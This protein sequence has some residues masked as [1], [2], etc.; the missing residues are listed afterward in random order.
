MRERARETDRGRD[1][2]RESQRD[3]DRER[4]KEERKH[5]QGATEREQERQ[6]KRL[7]CRNT[8]L[9][10]MF[11]SLAVVRAGEYCTYHLGGSRHDPSNYAIKWCEHDCCGDW[12]DQHC[13]PAV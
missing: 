10:R 9:S 3:R 5:R 11:S 13:C 4:D 12:P 1:R 6:R 2:A 8:E 7:Y